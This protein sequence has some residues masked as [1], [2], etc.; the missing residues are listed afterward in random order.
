MTPAQVNGIGVIGAKKRA[1]P[2]FESRWPVIAIV[3][4]CVR[5]L[6]SRIEWQDRLSTKRV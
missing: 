4:A 1:T 6:G 3:G 2:N 5:P